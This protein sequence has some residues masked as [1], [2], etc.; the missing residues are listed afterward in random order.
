MRVILSVLIIFFN[1]QLWTKADDIKDFEI[2]GISI[3]DSALDFFSKEQIT[4]NTWDYPKKKFKRVQNDK[5]SFFKIY[6]AVDF[7]F[8]TNDQNYKIYSLSGILFYDNKNIK[9]CY[10]KM[11]EIVDDIDDLFQGLKKPQKETYKHAADKSGKSTITDVEYEFNNGDTLSVMC[12]DYSKDHG[13]QDHLS[14]TL[15]TKEYRE[16]IPTA[17]D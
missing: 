6:D 2:E 14:L 7:N 15:S 13:S 10:K 8:K 4:K 12:Y 3:G 11:D 1:F 16:W 9:E 17:Y 5:L